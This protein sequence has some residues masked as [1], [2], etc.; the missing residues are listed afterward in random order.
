MAGIGY[1][2]SPRCAPLDVPTTAREASPG[3]SVG[4]KGTGRL[5]GLAA[6]AGTAALLIVQGAQAAIGPFDPRWEAQVLITAGIVCLTLLTQRLASE[7]RQAT[8]ARER[9]EL[10]EAS[11]RVWPLP[12][13]GE[14]NAQALGVFPPARAIEAAYVER[15]LDDTLRRAVSGRVPLVLVGEPLAGKS[16]SALEAVRKASPEARVV[17]PRDAKALKQLLEQDA[18]LGFGKE[19]RVL[20]LD[21]LSRHIEALDDRV[22]EGLAEAGVPVV[23][24]AREDTWRRMLASEAEDGEAAKAL[25]SRARTFELPLVPSA[26]ERARATKLVGARDWSKGLGAAL[27]STGIETGAPPGGAPAAIEEAAEQPGSLWRR[28]DPVVAALAAACLLCVAWVAWYLVDG[29]FKKPETPSI[30]DQVETAKAAGEQGNRQVIART[31][32]DFHGSGSD[33]YFFAFGDE[34]DTPT[35][36]Q[37]ADEIQVWDVRGDR[38]VRMLGFEPQLLGDEQ[39]LFQYRGV[40]DVDGDGADELVGGYGTEAIRGEL[41]VPFAVDWDTDTQSYTLIGLTPEPPEFATRPRSE[42]VRGLRAA[43]EREL[44]LT[45][46]DADSNPLTLSGYPAQDFAVSESEQVL[47]NAYVTRIRPELSQRLV[48]LHPHL[49]HRT[50]GPPQ[51]SR[52]T[53][54]GTDTVTGRL[55]QANVR[56]LSGAVRDFWADLSEDR[57]CAP[58]G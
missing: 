2:L 40:A 36:R 29:S 1:E 18:A 19:G 12:A 39:T 50:G 56:L 38:L 5:V 4:S 21:G 23:A 47:V 52:C 7:Y 11:V 34:A 43:Y 54:V 41:L 57:Y 31:K 8:E 45:D 24:T 32:A 22:L 33:S 27:G 17:A 42:D 14:A 44:T 58:A 9:E 35:D 30:A 28:I 13:A 16:R 6:A 48:E 15:D 37:R 20:W 49:F 55:P 10:L 53:L 26:E 3:Y 51:V 46:R 25:A